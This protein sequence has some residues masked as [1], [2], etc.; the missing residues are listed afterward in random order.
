ME[1][2]RLDFKFCLVCLKEDVMLDVNLSD[3]GCD[4]DLFELCGIINILLFYYVNNIYILLL[5]IYI[6]CY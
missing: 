6:M 1:N 2:K 3:I 4:G 5:L